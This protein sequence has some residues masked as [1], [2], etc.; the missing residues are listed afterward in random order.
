MSQFDDTECRI[1]SLQDQARLDTED[2]N[3]PEPDFSVRDEGTLFLLYPQSEAAK[4]WVEEHIPEDA[5][6]WGNAV[7]V[8]HRY[9]QDILAGINEDGLIVDRG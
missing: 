8:E 5:T 4:A 6:Y 7:V 3:S 9:I 1:L 2:Y